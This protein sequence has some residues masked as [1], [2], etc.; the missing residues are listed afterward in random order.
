MPQPLGQAQALDRVFAEQQCV[1]EVKALGARAV[2]AL[3]KAGPRQVIRSAGVAQLQHA[4]GINQGRQ[5]V[6][7]GQ[8]QLAQVT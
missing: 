6:V 3:V 7:I 5:R 1:F 8:V 2:Q 4:L